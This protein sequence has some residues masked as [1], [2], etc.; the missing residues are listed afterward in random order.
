M[1]VALAPPICGDDVPPALVNKSIQKFINILIEK[2]MRI[3]KYSIGN[4][5]KSKRNI[6]KDNDS[7]FQSSSC[8]HFYCNKL[9]PK[10]MQI[11]TQREVYSC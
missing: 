11:R 2:G 5:P 8:R 10:N 9:M 6:F 7:N 1:T 4:E 3:D